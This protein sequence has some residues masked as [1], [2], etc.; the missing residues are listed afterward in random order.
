[1]AQSAAPAVSI[2]MPAYNAAAYLRE[3]LDS[4][5]AQTFTDFELIAVDDG[6]TDETPAI[7]AD[8][9]A[10]DPRIRV[11]VQENGG[12]G[13][14]RVTGFAEVRGRWLAHVDADDLMAPELLEHAFARGEETGADMVI[15]RVESFDDQTGEVLQLDYAFR[16]YN[17]PGPVF[18][19][20]DA[21]DA[22]YVSFQNWVWNKFV[23]MDFL[24]KNG[25][26]FIDIPR[27]ADIPFSCKAFAAAEKIALLDEFLYR[28]RVNNAGSAMATSDRS[29]LSFYEGFKDV[30]A[31]LVERGLWPLY[32]SG[33][34]NW[35]NCSLFGNFT[36]AKTV[37][38]FSTIL[39]A[40][41]D[42]GFAL[43]EFEKVPRRD[44]F[45]Q[46]E[47]EFWRYLIEQ[48]P[49]REKLFSACKAR[50]LLTNSTAAAARELD[51][52]HTV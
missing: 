40:F 34:V 22:I 9:A 49:P 1:M 29:P 20:R 14:A 46:D 6:S 16:D 52:L 35:V 2:I 8:Y 4:V 23:R 17:M 47:Y 45:R 41:L 51:I 18:D 24:R 43:F 11:I 19:P 38:G 44:F 39:D 25:I 3:T 50:H 30:H 33:F 5:L 48:N 42:E 13:A 21:A 10:R 32:R 31:F 28:Y 15:Y 7:L 26:G 37:E 36:T 27:S 12:E